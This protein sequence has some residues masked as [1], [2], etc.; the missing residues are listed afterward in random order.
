MV[1]TITRE[2]TPAELALLKTV[3]P[4]A[5]ATVEDCGIVSEQLLD[6]WNVALDKFANGD[7]ALRNAGI[8]QV[9]R[10]RAHIVNNEVSRALG[11][12]A[13]RAL[14]PCQSL[15]QPSSRPYAQVV[16]GER[17]EAREKALEAKRTREMTEYVRLCSVVSAG[18][19]MHQRLSD[20]SE[21]HPDK[22]QS[23]LL[24]DNFTVHELL[25]LGAAHTPTGRV[26]KKGTKRRKGDRTQPGPFI[27][28]ILT[29]LQKPLLLKPQPPS[30]AATAAD[31]APSPPPP[32]TSA[33]SATWHPFRHPEE[34]R[35]P[36]AFL[37]DGPWCA[38]LGWVYPPL[39]TSLARVDVPAADWIYE[40]L[41]SR[42]RD[43]VM[44]NS[45]LAK[46]IESVAWEVT[47]YH[48]ARCVAIMAAQ[49]HLKDTVALRYTAEGGCLLDTSRFVAQGNAQGKGRAR[50]WPSRCPPNPPP[51]TP[52]A[53][54]PHRQP[55]IDPACASL[56]AAAFLE[57]T[58]QIPGQV[59]CPISHR[60]PPTFRNL[61]ASP[62]PG[63]TA[64][65]WAGLAAHGF[66]PCSQLTPRDA[67]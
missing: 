55:N 45:D 9:S 27:D 41:L 58:D 54:R 31:T 38:R 61:C 22:P 46:T 59:P 40:E 65:V 44:N 25:A 24:L 67:T 49:G 7:D 33:R 63:K 30:T 29:L 20:L 62:T 48:L 12:L 36:S 42:L 3:M 28:Q 47:V 37:A 18:E 26:T 39:P 16:V 64:A 32:I 23:I 56:L 43:F 60:P 11:F 52:R 6:D 21:Q 51:P 1:A 57:I 14:R 10:A 35:M 50:V 2:I 66:F 5:V 13:C 19:A 17:R 53:L 4:T 15:P 34:G 8:L